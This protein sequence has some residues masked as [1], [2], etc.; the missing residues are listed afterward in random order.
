MPYWISASLATLPA[1]LA[2]YVGVGVPW[3]LVMLPRQDWRRWAEVA[4]LGV[5]AG[6]A[7]VTTWMFILGTVGE[8]VTEPLLRPG[9]V[10]GGTLGLSLAGILIVL[11]RR[12][13]IQRDDSPAIRLAWDETLLIALIAAALCVRWV[14][15][16][17]WPFTA[18]DTLWVYGSLGRQF[19][20]EGFI[21]TTV[22]Y[23]P[24]SL[25]L[26]YTFGQLAFGSID[27]HA[28]R[29]GLLILHAAT[30]GA[31]YVLGSRH[32][33]RRTG[34][35]AAALWALYP[36]VGEWSRAGDLEILLTGLF[37]LTTAYFVLAWSGAA[38]RRW[39]ALLAGVTLG[40][41]LWTKPTMGAFVWGMLL[42]GAFELVQL[43]FSLQ[44]A[45]PRLQLIV[46][47]IA[48]A[49]P[50]GAVWYVRNALLGLDVIVLP[51]DFWL[52]IAAQSGA[53]FGWLMLAAAVYIAYVCV[54]PLASRPRLLWLIAGCALILLATVPSIVAP[55]RLMLSEYGLLVAGGIALFVELRRHALAQGDA[56]PWQAVRRLGQIM[57]IGV[58]FFITW[59]V[60]YSYHYRL[61]FPIVPLLILPTAIILSRWLPLAFTRKS[62][63]VVTGTAIILFSLPGIWS[64]V[65]D[66]HAGSDYLWSD[67]LP[68]DHARYTS[69]NAALMNV[70]D[71]LQVWIDEQPGAVLSVSAPGVLRLPFFFPVHDIRVDAFPQ[72]YT[73]LDGVEYLVYGV[74]E[75]ISGFARI[76]PE[77]SQVVGLFGRA[78]VARPA[79]GFDDGNFRYQVFELDL[80]GRFTRPVINAQ[81]EGEV[82]IGDIVRFLGHDLG[83]LEFWPGRR[84]IT[85]L[86]WQ[87]LQPADR[88]LSVFVHLLD[89]QGNLIDTWDGPIGQSE[90]GHYSMRAWEPGEIISDERVLS[91]TTGPSEDAAGY[92]LVIGIYDPV[93]Q[94][95]L[96]VTVDG[97][98][99]GDS[100]LLDNRFR[101]QVAPP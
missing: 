4:T 22:G 68:D 101:V 54:G 39:Y 13:T 21:P 19:F 89:A 61:S 35:Y 91:L 86:F 73:D 59:F 44:R 83:G 10:A 8:A 45:W 66:P 29:A 99:A 32:F 64:A 77:S 6:A 65:P 82:L 57:V 38:H 79:W 60:S 78:D 88:E 70:V 14:V 3:A 25:A 95:R 12:N 50:M 47:T 90:I 69:G 42:L 94:E 18:Y 27:D 36:H 62:T 84:I 26:Q 81:P 67:S 53:E 49:L 97:Q 23:Y 9:P 72:S 37:T 63:A 58:P 11:R 71:G 31:V 33:G 80:G 46:L 20:V 98:P 15:I 40:I 75:S 48:A 87:P 28:A 24:P 76:P 74:P 7:L 51:S 16:S 56:Y 100:I 17:Y 2:L 34:L 93:T 1:F 41:G 5:F 55:R 96:P 52:T 43:R 30:I 92:Q 85:H